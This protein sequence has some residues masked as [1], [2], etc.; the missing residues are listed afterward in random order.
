MTAEK[1]RANAYSI[2]KVS[3]HRVKSNYYER[4][5]VFNV[6][7]LVRLHQPSEV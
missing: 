6:L 2:R 4:L 3:F 5:E 7:E 1:F